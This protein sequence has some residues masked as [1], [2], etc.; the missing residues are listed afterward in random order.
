MEINYNDKE[1][2]KLI[3]RVD[4]FSKLF[5]DWKLEHREM[6]NKIDDVFKTINN[7]LFNQDNGVFIRIEKNTRF[8]IMVSKHLWFIYTVLASSIIA[9]TIKL[10]L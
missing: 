2:I 8:R 9:I 10:F 6:H 7:S 3:E 1:L 4:N 5:N